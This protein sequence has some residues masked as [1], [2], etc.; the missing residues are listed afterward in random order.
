MKIICDCGNE[1][2]IVVNGKNETL[3]IDN[4]NYDNFCFWDN[5]EEERSG[6]YCEL[7][8]REIIW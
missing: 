5:H 4:E 6:I 1:I 7:C 8:G 2:N 3:R